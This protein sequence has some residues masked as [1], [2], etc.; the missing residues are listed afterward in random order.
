MASTCAT[1]KIRPETC[2]YRG[3]L[4]KG[5][6]RAIHSSPP[7]D[8]DAIPRQIDYIMGASFTVTTDYLKQDSLWKF[9]LGSATIPSTKLSI[10]IEK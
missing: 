3:S 6:I 7:I 5:Q 9:F 1:I 4:C 2:F 10:L 8:T